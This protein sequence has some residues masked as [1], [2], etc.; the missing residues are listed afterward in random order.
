MAN[1][2]VHLVL[3]VQSVPP[4]VSIPNM[5]EPGKR[6]LSSMAPTIVLNAKT[7]EVVFI[8]GAAGGKQIP[9]SIAISLLR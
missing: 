2:F 9:T 1:K 7:N 5:I 3:L 4:E 8:I 6:P